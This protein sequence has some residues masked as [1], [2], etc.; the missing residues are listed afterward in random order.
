MNELNSVSSKFKTLKPDELVRTRDL[1]HLFFYGDKNFD[2]D[3]NFNILT[4]TINFI[5][6]INDLSELFIELMKLVLAI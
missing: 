5:K 6:K 3:T 4:A 2:N 1:K